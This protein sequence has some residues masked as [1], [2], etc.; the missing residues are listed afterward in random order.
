[1]PEAPPPRRRLRAEERDALIRSG[2]EPLGAGERPRIVLVCVALCAAAAIANIVLWVVGWEVDGQDV[3]AL[4]ALIPFVL[5]AALAVGL[6]RTRLLAVAGMQ[7]L[8]GLTA[9]FASGALLVSSNV[10]SALL[11]VATIGVCGALFWP[12]VRVNARA[13][14]RDRLARGAGS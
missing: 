5:L 10:Q 2:L 13:G 12:L 14:L 6:W 9:L 1:M 8:L 7:V 4:G 3:G 11:S